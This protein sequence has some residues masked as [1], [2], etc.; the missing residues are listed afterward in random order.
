MASQPAPSTKLPRKD[1]KS[2]SDLTC[3]VRIDLEKP[4]A[5]HRW[6][7]KI[8][9]P[10]NSFH[11]SFSDSRFGGREGALAAAKRCR[12]VELKLRPSLNAY[13][14]AIRPK[15]TNKSGI[16]GVRLGEKVV[17]RGTKSWIY[18][19]WIATG[20]PFSGG[21]T[22]TKYFAISQYGS[23][24]AA[25]AAAIGQRRAWEKSLKTSVEENL[26]SGASS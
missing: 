26:K 3:I 13:E 7:V 5:Q 8:I 16:V 10:G 19:A 24:A 12:D 22:K 9:R 4:K 25:K 2:N 14:Q 11:R 15:I 6:E 23:S 20:T 21:R 18:P 1:M 17:T